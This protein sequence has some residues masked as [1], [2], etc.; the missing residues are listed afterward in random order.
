LTRRGGDADFLSRW[1]RRKLGSGAQDA[2]APEA[3]APAPEPEK[4]DAEILAEHGLP[5]PDELAPGDDIRGFMNGAI[6]ARLRNR[7][8]RKLWVGNPVLANLDELVEYGED[9]TDAATVV[10]S[11]A[12][13]WQAGRGYL[14]EAPEEP[15]G[16]TAARERDRDDAA[17]PEPAAGRD[18]AE[19]APAHGQGNAPAGSPEAVTA[20]E[21]PRPAPRRRMA[22][23]VPDRGSES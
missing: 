21:E 18:E 11:L 8:L 23:R 1:S 19:P 7:A 12:S 14:P 2:P 17:D 6:P 20:P 3:P 4:S 10:E 13:A 16:E 22:F 9:Y 5:D 15:P